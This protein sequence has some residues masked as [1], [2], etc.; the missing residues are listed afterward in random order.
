MWTPFPR[1]PYSPPNS[2]TPNSATDEKQRVAAILEPYNEDL[3]LTQEEDDAFGQLARE[4]TARHPLRTYLWIPAARAVVMWFTPRIELLP[5]SGNV[6]PLAQMYDEDPADQAFT[7]L[8]FLLNILYIALAVWG[9]IK[10][11]RSR[12][13]Q[14]PDWRSSQARSPKERDA[15][16]VAASPPVNDALAGGTKWRGARPAVAFLIL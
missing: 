2:A 1:A 16:T 9:A 6:F 13:R 11:W 5:I 14:S 7:I 3:A 8:L 10:L 4:R 12:D 15:P